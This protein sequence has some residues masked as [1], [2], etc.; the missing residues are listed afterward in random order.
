MHSHLQMADGTAQVMCGTYTLRHV[1]VPPFHQLGWRITQ[2]AINPVVGAKSD[3][4]SIQKLLKLGCN[5]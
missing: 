3:A 5:L 1:D 2:V 4:P